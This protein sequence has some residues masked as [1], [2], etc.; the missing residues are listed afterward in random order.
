MEKKQTYNEKKLVVN[1]IEE[2]N[3]KK[4]E[5]ERKGKH[6]FL[7]HDR[8]KNIYLFLILALL[9]VV[10]RICHPSRI[11]IVII[12]L[13]PRKAGLTVRIHSLQSRQ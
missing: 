7:R 6:V 8:T 5:E 9:T 11:T 3:N 4:K 12:I 10:G 13:D 2:E 1:R